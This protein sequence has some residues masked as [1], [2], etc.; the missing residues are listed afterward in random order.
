MNKQY[1]DGNELKVL[2]NPLYKHRVTRKELE[3]TALSA[4]KSKL[5]EEVKGLKDY[6]NGVPEENEVSDCTCG[7]SYDDCMCER[8]E[9]LDDVI[10]LTEREI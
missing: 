5:I 2:F 10:S 6:K 4:Y 8:N 7:Y 1:E 9:A 3:D